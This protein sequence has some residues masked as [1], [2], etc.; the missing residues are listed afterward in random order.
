MTRL[1]LAML[2]S[3]IM[4]TRGAHDVRD[5][6]PDVATCEAAIAEARIE[7]KANHSE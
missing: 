2:R 7:A 1:S 3:S 5:F 6:T 4:C